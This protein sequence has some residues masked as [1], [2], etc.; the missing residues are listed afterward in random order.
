MKVNESPAAL[1]AAG[2][3]IV[4]RE[5]WLKERIALLSAEKDLTRQRDALGE[6]VRALP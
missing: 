5:Q 3:R 4:T 1:L 2:H 6:R